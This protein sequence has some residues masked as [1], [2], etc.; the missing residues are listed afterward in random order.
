MKKQQKTYLLLTAVIVIWGL[1]GYQIY[2]R[3]N[4]STPELETLAIENKFQRQEISEQS[5]YKLKEMYRDPFLGKFPKKKS[6]IRKINQ[7]KT[8]ST[9]PFPSV[10]Y[11]GVIE[12]NNS[13]SYILTVKGK[14]QIIKKGEMFQGVKL[15]KATK[16]EATVKFQNETKTIVK[17]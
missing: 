16:E 12:G 7:Q 10:V 11:N 8:K 9:I 1:I 6:T 3:L 15:I 4:P 5:F 14:Q 13:K 2:N 17:Q